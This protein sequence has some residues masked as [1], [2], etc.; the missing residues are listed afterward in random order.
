MVN[1]STTSA[2]RRKY[3]NGMIIRGTYYRDPEGYYIVHKM[4]H[5]QWID[6]PL[7]GDP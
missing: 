1:Q 4:R 3:L 7:P 6:R 5:D 2:G